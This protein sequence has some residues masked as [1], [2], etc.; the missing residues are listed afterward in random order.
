MEL[1][2]QFEDILCYETTQRLV[3]AHEE[4]VETAIPEYCPDITRIVDTVGQLTIQEKKSG[5]ERCTV[6]GSVKVSVL[7]T[8]EEAAGLRS[9]TL[10]V[11]FS[12]VLED[13]TLASCAVLQ[14]Q[15]RVLLAEGRV[16]TSRKLYIKVLPEIS[17]VGYRAV[18]RSI[19]CATE[20]EDSLRRRCCKKEVNLLSAVSEKHFPFTENV[21]VEEGCLPED[22]LLY[23]LCPMIRSAQRLGGKLMVKGEMQLYALYRGED[24]TLHQH[25]AAL[26]F[27]QILDS[28]ELPEEAEYEL[29]P[30]MGEHEAHIIRTDTGGGFTLTG[31]VGVCIRVYQRRTLTLLDDIYS[32]RFDTVAERRQL[33][34]PT[35]Q[36]DAAVQQEGQLRLEF[37]GTVPFVSVTSIDCAPPEV[38]PEEGKT[39]LRTMLHVRLLYLDESG[40]PVSAERT[41]ELS[42][43]VPRV[44]GAVF[45]RCCCAVLR[46]GGG[47]CQVSLPIT[48]L[49]GCTG[50]A[51]LDTL[52]SVTLTEPEGE[53]K[54]RPSLIL[55]RMCQGETLW[56]IAKRYQTD[57]AAIRSA[58][59]M[60]GEGEAYGEM[61][62]IPCNRQQ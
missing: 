50:T 4:T 60:E 62:L 32:T 48:F 59:G 23:R 2:L 61:L 27:S 8:S 5:E 58:N 53:E 25:S 34:L 1:G 3:S 24:Q 56:D 22:L 18:R 29:L 54:E 44:E 37:D 41:V 52:T 33:T 13:R 38:F 19:C 15:G 30:H 26:P 35:A 11:P 49:T 14:A 47:T 43:E 21:T 40:A 42:A 31:H 20:E 28:A 55:C 57:E 45:A 16:V 17:V 7:Y 12:C 6:S 51:T 10:S 9:L 39:T 36:P 46:S